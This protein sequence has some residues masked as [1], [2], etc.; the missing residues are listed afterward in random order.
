MILG[1]VSLH[2]HT[3]MSSTTYGSIKAPSSNRTLIIGAGIVGSSLAK[4]LSAL[5]PSREVVV[6]DRSLSA[7]LG[8]TGH[9]PG[10]VGQLNELSTLTTLA[11]RSVKA[12][13][14]IEGGF[15]VVGGVEVAE[16]AAGVELLKARYQLALEAG[17]PAKE[18]NAREAARLAPAFVDQRNIKSGL[19]F[20]SDGTAKAE[21]ITL[22]NRQ[23]ASASGARFLEA[24]VKSL[25]L[26]NG[27]IAGV[28]TSLGFVPATDVVLTTG[29]WAA[30]LLPSLSVIPVAHPYIHSKR[31]PARPS[32]S[33]FVRFPESHTY[34]RDHGATDGL[35]SY[36]HAP[37]P[38]DVSSSQTAIDTWKPLFDNV[39]AKAFEVL[40]KVE[41]GG[42]SFAGGSAFNGV[43]SMTPDNLP[44]VG[45]IAGAPGLWCA[46]AIWV[47][48]AAGCAELL[49]KRI[50]GELL[51]DEDQGLLEALRPDRFAGM[52]DGV[53]RER[54]LGLY[55]NIYNVK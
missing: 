2:V 19:L 8:S 34:I 42:A 22:A 20:E 43:F 13:S 11:K 46:V 53:L 50:A 45:P 55:N 5:S 52:P 40:P 54:S 37:I 44:F 41:D 18:A 7:L 49:A 12:Y 15:D 1:I 16:T 38:V 17:L 48:H 25:E 36:A 39:L 47:T 3:D 6:L 27:T 30:S 26:K 31:R 9:A 23:T 28:N 4:C 32:S 33:P 14:D 10:F 29:I 21:V 51:D 35:G 24:D